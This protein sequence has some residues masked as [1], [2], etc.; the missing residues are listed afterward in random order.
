MTGDL[1]RWSL[2]AAEAR[3]ARP[4][5]AAFDVD[6]TVTTHSCVLP[7][8]RLVGGSVSFTARMGVA[9][10]RNAPAVVRRDRDR[11]KAIAVRQALAGRRADEIERLAEQF[12]ERVEQR[13]LRSDT[14]ARMRW[15]HQHGHAVVLVSASL[16]TYLRPLGRR[17]GIVD[18]VVGTELAV[19]PDGR[20][21]GELLGANCRGAE[22]VRR[23]H[24]WL[25][26]HHGGRSDVLLWAYGDSPDDRDL[27]ADAD[28]PVWSGAVIMPWSA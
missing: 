7:F 19:G 21:T 16:A 5:V 28:R 9:T 20:C 22:K 26:Q 10:I 25:D 23:L 17:L 8:L 4:V 11:L 6:R 18:G 24:G 27:L 2:V 1:S 15:H 13:W 12:A 14:M 3:E